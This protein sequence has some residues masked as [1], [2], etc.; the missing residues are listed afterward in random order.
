MLRLKSLKATNKQ[1]KNTNN[2]S[3]YI[4]AKATVKRATKTCNLFC[5][6]AAKGVG[7]RCCA[8]YHPRSNLSCNKSC[9]SKLRAVNADF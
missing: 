3:Q 7:K 4:N 9:C 8:F 6:V 5:D 1:T 2:K